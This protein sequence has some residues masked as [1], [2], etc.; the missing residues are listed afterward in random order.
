M[1]ELLG[2]YSTTLCLRAHPE[3]VLPYE[4]KVRITTFCTG[5]R[6][7]FGTC[8]PCFGLI[9]DPILCKYV[10]KGFKGETHIRGLGV[11]VVLGFRM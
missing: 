9:M 8:F 7:R 4:G 11:L 1:F 5:L 6:S 2:V 10:F 3:N